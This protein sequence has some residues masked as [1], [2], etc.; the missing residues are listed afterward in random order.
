MSTAKGLEGTL[1]GLRSRGAVSFVS[2]TA[3]TSCRGKVWIGRVGRSLKL[4]LPS[5]PRFISSPRSAGTRTGRAGRTTAPVGRA[6][7]A[8]SVTLGPVFSMGICGLG[9]RPLNTRERR[10]SLSSA[11]PG[12]RTAAPVDRPGNSTAGAT[13]AGRATVTRSLRSPLPPRS[14]MAFA[15]LTGRSPRNG[16]PLITRRADTSSAARNFLLSAPKSFADTP[17]TARR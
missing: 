4:S 9:S 15:G 13:R 16:S 12:V 10:N 6:S 3:G 5:R 1:I 8:P 2:G 14:G 11:T 7:I 17:V